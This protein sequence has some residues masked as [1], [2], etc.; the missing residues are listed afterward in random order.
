MANEIVPMPMFDPL[1]VDLN[2]EML[3]EA[4]EWVDRSCLVRI[5]WDLPVPLH[6]VRRMLEDV[7]K[8][9]GDL[10]IFEVG[11]GLYQ[12]IFPSVQ[13]RN[14][15]QFM[16]IVVKLA[17]IPIDCRTLAFGRQMQKIG[18]V[19]RMMLAL[20]RLSMWRIDWIFVGL[21]DE[22]G[23]KEFVGVE[24]STG[25]KTREASASD[26]VETEKLLKRKKVYDKGK[27]KVAELEKEPKKLLLGN[28]GIV[29]RVLDEE[30]VEVSKSWSDQESN[31][32]DVTPWVNKIDTYG[33]N[34]GSI[35]EMMREDDEF[36]KED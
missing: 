12:F 25:T 31:D 29:I 27:A 28:K 19:H 26:A 24:N 36:D 7:W 5:F 20:K 33:S 1:V 22:V 9:S 10:N 30:G 18:E 3:H 34:E 8:C 13:K 15:L 4:N 6:V 32:E 23:S 14:W 17:G 16:D 21:Q 2:N 35:R 11:L